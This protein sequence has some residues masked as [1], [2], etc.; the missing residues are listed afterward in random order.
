MTIKYSTRLVLIFRL[1]VIK[2]PLDRRGYLQSINEKKI[3]Y[4]YKN[5]LYLGKLYWVFL[6]I[7]CQKHYKTIKEIPDEEVIRIKRLIPELHFHNCDF[8]N[9]ENWGKEDD[10]F[11]LIDYGNT[12]FISTLY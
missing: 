5:N 6:G 1:F 7:V 11:I 8:W 3:W 2:I 12:P 10:K 9:Y 4:K